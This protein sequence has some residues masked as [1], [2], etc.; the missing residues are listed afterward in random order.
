LKPGTRSA[1]RCALG[2]WRDRR[3]QPR[4]AADR[5]SWRLQTPFNEGNIFDH[6]EVCYEY[7]N[8]VRAFMSQRQIANC[9]S[10]NS[11]YLLGASGIATCGWNPPTIRSQNRWRF[12][13]PRPGARM[14]QTE[15]NELFA[16]IRP[17]N[18]INDGVW[19]AHSTLMA[20][21]GRTAAYTGKEVTWEHILRSQDKLVPEPL[22]WDTKLPIAPLAV[23]GQSKLV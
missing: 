3:F 13:G 5:P 23:P 18:P 21:M 10:E 9:Y 7:E 6:I 17:G 11:D 16:S 12:D 14:Y 19:V 15:H 20:I 4:W 2:G 1:A 8:G 22:T